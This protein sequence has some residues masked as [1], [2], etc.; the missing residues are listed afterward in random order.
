VGSQ[1]R[2]VNKNKGVQEQYRWREKRK[3]TKSCSEQQS[4]G[5][6]TSYEVRAAAEGRCALGCCRPWRRLAQSPSCV[7][8]KGWFAVEN[9]TT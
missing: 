7:W 1:V 4:D 2:D 8:T 9:T 6:A 5:V 3:G